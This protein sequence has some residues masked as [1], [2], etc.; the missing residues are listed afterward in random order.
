MVAVVG[1]T[2]TGEG[3]PPPKRPPPPGI[4]QVCW[5]ERGSVNLAP[6]PFRSPRDR[7]A[8]GALGFEVSFAGLG[9]ADDDVGGTVA[10]GVVAADAE[11]VDEGRDVGELGGGEVELRHADAAFGGDLSDELAVL[12]FEN[13]FGPDE[14]GSA[15]AAAAGILAVA[16]GA[17]GAVDRFAAL[18]NRG[19]GGRALR[20]RVGEAS[21]TAATAGG[22]PRPPR[23]ARRGGC[24]GRGLCECG[25][26]RQ[27]RDQE[28]RLLAISTSQEFNW[29]LMNAA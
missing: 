19:V 25:D 27:R 7:V 1:G 9:V 28:L 26:S 23:P 12:I 13:D 18:D 3:C 11:A 14:A 21:A 6:K 17:L 24:C 22:A 5:S 15:F 16:E 29:P 10:G 8:G 20:I 2:L 4:S